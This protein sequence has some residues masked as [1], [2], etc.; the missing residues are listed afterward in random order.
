MSSEEESK[1]SAG[2]GASAMAAASLPRCDVCLT[3]ASTDKGRRGDLGGNASRN[4][5]GTCGLAIHTYVLWL[6]IYK[7]INKRERETPMIGAL[8]SG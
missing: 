7:Y 1:D 4:E 8:L 2:V 6:G 5:W 3:T